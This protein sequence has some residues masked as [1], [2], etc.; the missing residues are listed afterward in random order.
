VG[1]IADTPEAINKPVLQLKVTDVWLSFC[2]EAGD[3]VK[4]DRRDALTLARLY[5]LVKLTEVWV[6][7][8]VQEAL[9][10]LTRA[11]LDI[12]QLQTKARQR[13]LAFM[14]RYGKRLPEN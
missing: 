7:D 11:R 14:L 13:R 1:E 3:C 8:N 2:Y 5:R 6:P 4:T 9:R 12:R 10:D